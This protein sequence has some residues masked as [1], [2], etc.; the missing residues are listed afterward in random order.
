MLKNYFKIALRNIKKNKV[1]SLINILGLAVGL[2]CV[3]LIGL[4]IQEELSYDRFHENAENIYRLTVTEVGESPSWSGTPLPLGPALKNQFP[5]VENFVRF[6]TFP[7]KPKI[8]ISS[9]SSKFFEDDFWLTDPE[10]FTVFNFE[11]IKGDP[12]TALNS[13]YNVVISESMA[14]KYFSDE[15]PIGKVLKFEKETVFTITGVMKNVPGN[16]SLQFDFLG[17]ILCMNEMYGY[18]T[19][20]AWGTYNYYTY[21]QLSDKISA[22]EFM[23]KGSKYLQ[24]KYEAD[25][26]AIHVASMTDIHLYSA[27]VRDRVQRG[28]ISTVYYFSIIA[29]LILFIASINFVNLYTANSEMRAKEIGLR[30]VVGAVKRQLIFQIMSEAIIFALIALPIALLLAKLFIPSLNFITGK[31]LA[32]DIIGN[33]YYFI[34]IV[35]LTVITGFLSG[36]YPAFFISALS[37]T[38]I[39]GREKLRPDKKGFTL[40]NGLVVFQFAVSIFLIS[41]SIIIDDQ[42]NYVRN[43]KLGYN[44]ENIITIPMYDDE[45]KSKY[46]VFKNEITDHSKIVAASATSFRPSVEGWREGLYFEGRT[47]ED[48]IS[49]F[50]LACDY[51]F[52]EMM[53]L[54]ITTGRAFNKEYPSDLKSAYI[55]NETAVKEIGWTPEEAVGK[56]FGRGEGSRIIGVVKD[57]NFQ[58]LRRETKPLAINILP[59]QFHYLAVKIKPGNVTGTVDFLKEKWNVVNAGKP[60]EFHFYD[61]EF[62]A[63]YKSDEKME[64]LFGTFSFIAI[65]LACMGLF[66]LSLFNVNSKMKEIGIRKVLGASVPNLMGMLLTNFIKLIVVGIVVAIPL[67]YYIMTDW[68]EG[69]AYRTEISIFVYLVAGAATLLIAFMTVSYQVIRAAQT[70]P[71]DVLKYE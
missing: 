28:D 51:D 41:S 21:L 7:F 66:G 52:V 20:N 14:R 24:E 46:E 11:L 1:F 61:E 16:S 60:F 45:S 13:P 27:G 5:E 48:D 33:R 68:L 67:V 62:D 43:K 58:S 40:R 19:F 29:V 23:Q 64:S 8:L 4:F 2:S 31:S 10:V 42:M 30:K 70:N 53:G 9:Q 47:D 22:E 35:F 25:D 44:K 6:N 59:G 50:R 32:L 37:P 18:D 34:G 3:L 65:F 57:F 71:V 12:E 56:V 63:M 39:I 38:S 54:E 36:V 69:F 49:F 15:D 17:S 26:V 55:L